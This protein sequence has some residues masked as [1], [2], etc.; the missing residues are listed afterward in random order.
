MNTYE[1]SLYISGGLL[2]LVVEASSISEALL[3]VIKH[4]E[5]GKG[6]V[7]GATKTCLIT[8]RSGE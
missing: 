2:S 6:E 1:I 4:P 7:V 3:T 5:Y 8:L